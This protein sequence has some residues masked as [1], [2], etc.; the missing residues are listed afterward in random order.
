[1]TGR[2]GGVAPDRLVQGLAEGVL[3]AT[4]DADPAGRVS[5]PALLYRLLKL[6]NLINRPFLTHLAGRYDLSL[7]DVR[8]LMTLAAMSEAASHELSQVTGVHP[9]NISR[10]VARLRRRGRIIEREDPGNRRRKILT[11]TP[12]GWELYARL[13]P[14]VGVISTFLFEALSPLEA[15]LLGKL[16]DLLTQRME[17]VDLNSP[18]LIDVQALAEDA[19]VHPQAA[20]DDRPPPRGRGR[21]PKSETRGYRR[22]YG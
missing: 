17:A 3:A 9:M 7:N 10:S 18:L 11:P 21:P 8:V 16:I 22:P 19:A 20:D 5:P 6:S 14:H 13:S 12:E 15:E 2:V 4:K 1:M